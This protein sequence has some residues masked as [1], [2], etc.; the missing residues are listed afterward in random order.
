MNTNQTKTRRP[1]GNLGACMLPWTEDFRFDEPAFQRHVEHAISIGYRDVYLMGTAGEGYALS[2]RQFQQVV[3]SFATITSRHKDVQPQVGIISLSMQQFVERIEF[4]RGECGIRSFQI[5]MPSWGA[6]SDDEVML[7]FTGV[8]GKFTDC[9]FLHY[10]LPRTKR[11]LNG[12]MYR[13]IADA[14]PN[15]VATKNSTGDYYRIADLMKHVPDLQHF[16]LEGGYAMGSLL[17]ECSLLCSFGEIWPKATWAFFEAG[18]KKDLET[19]WRLHRQINDAGGLLFSEVASEHIDGAYDKTMAWL[20][21][22]RFSNRLL[23][24]YLGLSESESRRVAEIFET[25]C[26]HLS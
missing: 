17:G 6:L 21:D 11:I 7:F 20:L 26:G 12:A 18:Q 23:P 22:R 1:P 16:F 10:N 3:R 13:R 25:R 9:T 5:S 4:A 15:L 2:D 14:C 8:C 19:L 24:P